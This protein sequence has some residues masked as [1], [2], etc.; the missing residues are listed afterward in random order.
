M[1]W[2]NELFLCTFLWSFWNHLEVSS[3]MCY[4]QMNELSS[5]ALHPSHLSSLL[6][7]FIRIVSYLEL[8]TKRSKGADSQTSRNLM[9]IPG[10]QHGGMICD[11]TKFTVSSD[12]TWQSSH[13]QSK[14]LRMA[15]PWKMRRRP[16]AELLWCRWDKATSKLECLWAIL[17]SLLSDVGSA[18]V[19]S[20]TCS[21]DSLLLMEGWSA[22]P[23]SDQPTG[24]FGGC[25]ISLPI[26]LQGLESTS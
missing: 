2:L 22:P 8:R 24:I 14:S 9:Q 23:G 21:L 7:S 12:S 25:L 16:F 26:P 13:S 10:R 15:L 18:G 20:C 17:M 19:C 3:G 6:S 5:S 4:T 1:D 11:S